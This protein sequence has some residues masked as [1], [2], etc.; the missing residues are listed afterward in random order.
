M[1]GIAGFVDYKHNCTVETM[2]KMIESINYRGPDN[3][4]AQVFKT[5]DATIGLG[6]SRLSIIDLSDLGN[7]PMSYENFQIVFNGEIYNYKVLKAELQTLGYVFNTNSDT[8]VILKATKEWGDEAVHRFIGMFVYCIYD[9]KKNQLSI[10][11]DRAG[12]KPLYYYFEDQIFLFGS[13]LKSL[14]PCSRFNKEIE[15]KIL[16]Q[17][18]QYGYIPAPYSIYKN[19]YK[20]MPGHRIV[21]DI[22][23]GKINIEQYWNSNDYYTINKID[24]S[25]KEAKEDVHK[26]LI[27]ACNYRMVADV[28]VGVFLSGGY[29]ST[30]VSAITHSQ[31]NNKL[32]TYTIGF[33]SENN[34]ALFAKSIANYIGTDHTEY[35]C[36][37]EDIKNIIPQLP[38]IYD[39][40]FGDVSAI[41]TILVSQLAKKDVKVV[42][43]ADGGDELF[44]GYTVYNKVIKY[45]KQLNK[46]PNSIK[47]ILNNKSHLIPKNQLLSIPKQHYLNS[48]T[49]SIS[50]NQRLQIKN[51][52][53]CMNEKPKSYID[54][55]FKNNYNLTS[56]FDINIDKFKINN[57]IPMAIDYSCYLPNDILTKVDRA[58]MSVSIEGREPLIDHRLHE[59][60]AQLPFN[61]K[62]ENE[63]NKKILKDIVHDYVPY[64]LMNRPKSGFS[65]PIDE[66]LRSE[67][68]FLIE[69]YLNENSLNWSGLL[70]VTFIIKQVQLF[71][72][73][74]MYY[75]PLIWRLLM[76][77]M[78]YEKWMK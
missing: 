55:F 59:Y 31:Q 26:L 77:Q 47:T 57:E 10:T 41:P 48:F 35:Y 52:Y 38:Y 37:T 2:T 46:I 22:D 63:V 58:T 66:L 28:P 8:E 6:Q 1:C 53:R 17:F 25:Y 12:V 54:N 4:G 61:F 33:E 78:W 67:L 20:L 13:E 9:N 29:D 30:A 3:L 36:S 32:K 56:P 5:N 71:K 51:L 24:I 75:T 68:D 69:Y 34:E 7:Q 62:F 15:D 72:A 45:N 49:E 14:L 19:C 43:S 23:K 27:S 39:E 18:L 64:P 73:K 42:L 40:P 11:R 44:C 60:V 74:K 76:F 50:T 70:N 65:F 21:L 16:P